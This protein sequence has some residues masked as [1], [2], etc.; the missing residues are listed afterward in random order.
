MGKSQAPHNCNPF[1]CY[2]RWNSLREHG[3]CVGESARD[4]LG[5]DY[6]IFHDASPEALTRCYHIKVDAPNVLHQIYQLSLL[7]STPLHKPPLI[8]LDIFWF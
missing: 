4:R 2:G 7:C 5:T 8:I 1:T 3:S 6:G